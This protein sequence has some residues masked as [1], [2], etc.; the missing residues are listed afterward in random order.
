M[1]RCVV[2]ALMMAVTLGCQSPRWRNR[3]ADPA[4]G[5]FVP[6]AP[7]PVAQGFVPG[8]PPGGQANLPAPGPGHAFPVVPQANGVAPAAGAGIAPPN[9]TTPFPTLPANPPPDHGGVAAKFE[10]H[11]QPAEARTPN[12]MRSRVLLG[13]PEALKDDAPAKAPTGEPPQLPTSPAPKEPAQNAPAQKAPATGLPVGIPRF[14]HVKQGIATGLRPTVDDGL[15]WLKANDFRTLV[16]LRLPGQDDEPDRQQA[17][18][19]GFQYESLEV[20]PDLLNKETV[21]E[22]LKVVGD[23]Q[24]RALF[25]YDRDGALAGGMWYVWLRLAED[26]PDDV[27]RVRARALG[28]REDGEGVHRTMWQAAQRYVNDAKAK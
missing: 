21:D 25:V 28:L 22:F 5:R 19:R 27:A 2:L 20:S 10:S 6:P 1:T 7:A 14:A 11:W 13:P 15:D 24:K 18:R 26:V 9:A 16:G 12:P 17:Q 3:D 23:P 4:A 8:I